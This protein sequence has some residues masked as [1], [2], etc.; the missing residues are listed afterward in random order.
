[1][2]FFY[3]DKGSSIRAEYSN[4]LA[5]GAHLH[6]HIELVYM[7]EGSTK[8]LV[9]SLECVACAGDVIIVFPNQIHQ[10]QKIDHEK[11]FLSIFPPDL[12][13]EFQSIFKYKL[14]VSPV[15]K[16]ASDNKRILPLIENIIETQT[17]KPPFYDTLIK[18]YFLALLS[19]LFQVVKFTET[20]SSDGD[21]IKAVLNFCSENYTQNIQLKTIAQALHISRT[22]ISHLFSEKLHMGFSE[23]IGMLRISDACNLLVSCDMSI[24]DISYAVGF[25]SPRSFNRLF[26]K[27]T[28]VTPRE[29]R[30][31]ENNRKAE[32]IGK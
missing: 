13:P 19:E 4:G 18:G 11:C 27:Y 23:Y 12:C 14:P 3:E 8:T 30:K 21:T 2:K 16:R 28:G 1:M 29:Y 10:Y 7:L 17:S 32:T 24:T 5:F 22:Y 6:N 26:L 9:D 20:K 15:I 31:T 25:N